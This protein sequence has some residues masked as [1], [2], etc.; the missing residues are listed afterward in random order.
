MQALQTTF[1]TGP[2][3]QAFT[4]NQEMLCANY[5]SQQTQS[6]F[7]HM[8]DRGDTLLFKLMQQS[9]QARQQPMI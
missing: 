9:T 2:L 8:S 5:R 4:Y 6:P 1:A 3:E 7:L